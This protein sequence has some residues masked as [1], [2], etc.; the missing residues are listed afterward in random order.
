MAK[1]RAPATCLLHAPLRAKPPTRHGVSPSLMVLPNTP[2]AHAAPAHALL[3][4]P[5][6][7]LDYLE[8]SALIPPGQTWHDRLSTGQVFDDAGQALGVDTL[9]VP[10][11]RIYY[12]RHIDNELRVPFDET[13]LYED[14]HLL[15]ADKPHF[16]PVSPT[17]RYVQET[18][19][20]RL[21][22]RTGLD[23][24]TPIHR[25]DRDT[26]GVVLFS[27]QIA[28]RNAYA[29]MF[30]ARQARK[31]YEAVA[32]Y[33]ADIVFPITRQTRLA[34]ATASFMQ[35]QEVPG[36]P[37]STTHI[38]ML[39]ARGGWA[40][41]QLQPITG[42]RHQLRVHM[43]ALGLP[44]RFD[45]IYPVLTPEPAL[46]AL[47]YTQPLQLLAQSIAFDDPVTGQARQF[48]SAHCL[49]LP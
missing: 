45:A 35:M 22:N 6:Y 17:G 30:R 36:P 29:A 34:T 20:V 42:Q 4:Q 28:S 37:N 14:A 12:Y 5:V 24:L 21:K 23:D 44:L 2:L 43:L 46:G 7:L 15:V 3:Q 31:V 19:L 40:R 47:D 25:L 11:L 9:Y 16:L 26:A 18:L 13:I 32:P 1:L 33:R 27:K 41:Y 48:R 39:E 8:Q 10:A 49:H 38:S